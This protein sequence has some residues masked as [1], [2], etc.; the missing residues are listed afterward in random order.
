MSTP[1]LHTIVVLNDGETY[2][3]IEGCT[4]RMY[5]AEQMTEIEAGANPSHI[6]AIKTID[7]SGGAQ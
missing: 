4:I 7:M 3:D 6:E 1:R 2:T 5:T